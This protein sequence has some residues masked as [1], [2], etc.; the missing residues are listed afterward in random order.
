M[1]YTRNFNDFL[2]VLAVLEWHLGF[3]EQMDIWTD[4][5]SINLGNECIEFIGTKYQ[6][7]T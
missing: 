1:H 3:E 4:G 7:R 5:R 6:V 2:I